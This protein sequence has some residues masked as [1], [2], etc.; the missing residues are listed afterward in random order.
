MKYCV[1]SVVVES[2]T[3]SDIVM[4]YKQVRTCLNKTLDPRPWDLEPRISDPTSVC[5]PS[6]I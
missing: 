3:F 4:L 1:S 2:V 6:K 5:V